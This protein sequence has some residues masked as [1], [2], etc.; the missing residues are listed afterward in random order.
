MPSG[1]RTLTSSHSHEGACHCRAIGFVYRTAL[2]PQQWPI[3]ACQ[4]TF[5][6]THVALSTSD[7]LGSL[8]FIERVP[9]A[10]NR[11][12]FGRKTADFLICRECG[13]YIGATMESGGKSFGII[14][15][16][17]LQSVLDLVREPQPMHYENEGSGERLARR[18]ARWTPIAVD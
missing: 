6:R 2:E 7:P 14:N 15:V 8:R 9:A 1:G 10:L 17:A 4:C 12:R 18:E 3:R 5:C 11:Y 13:A 16:R